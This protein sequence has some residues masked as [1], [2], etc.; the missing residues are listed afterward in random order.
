MRAF[1]PDAIL[2][3]GFSKT[4]APGI[5]IGWVHSTNFMRKTASLKYT[6]TMGTSTLSQAAIAE[7]MRSGGCDAHLNKLRRELAS[8]IQRMRQVLLREFPP[9]MCVSDPEGGY[10]LWVERCRRRR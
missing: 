8:Q 7:L 1:S 4:V 5:R 2:C 6:S 9:G 3:S 10:V